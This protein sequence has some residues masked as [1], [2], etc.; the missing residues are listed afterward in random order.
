MLICVKS[1]HDLSLSA[2]DIKE[3][4]AFHRDKSTLKFANSIGI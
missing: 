2:S 1:R 3:V 4:I